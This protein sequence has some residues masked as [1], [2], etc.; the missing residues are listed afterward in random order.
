MTF[1]IVAI[2]VSSAVPSRIFLI[3]CLCISI[4]L[5]FCCSSSKSVNVVLNEAATDFCKNHI[6][7]D[8]E[9]DMI[10]LPGICDWYGR[11]FGSNV[12]D[13]VSVLLPYVGYVF[14]LFNS[15]D[16]FSQLMFP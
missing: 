5:D 10:H 4:F 11:D 2:D 13:I 16:H 8:S 12:A 3:L 15:V 1:S 9:N 6:R 14:V 7:I